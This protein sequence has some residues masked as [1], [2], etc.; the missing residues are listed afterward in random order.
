MNTFI[1]ITIIICIIIFLVCSGVTGFMSYRTYNLEK[2]KIIRPFIGYEGEQLVTSNGESQ[3]KCP[4]GQKIN[5]IGAFYDVYD[6]YLQCT[7]NPDQTM[8]QTCA[9][10]MSDPNNSGKYIPIIGSKCVE[11]KIPPT[12]MVQCNVQHSDGTGIWDYIEPDENGDCNIPNNGNQQADVSILETSNGRKVCA[13][14]FCRNIDKNGENLTCGSNISGNTK[15]YPQ[16]ATAF[17]SEKCNG[18]EV[19]TVTVNS[20]NF[21]PVP[22][23]NNNTPIQS[24]DCS[25]TY[26]TSPIGTYCSLPISTGNFT[27]GMSINSQDPFRKLTSRNIGYKA[28]GIY[29]CS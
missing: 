21:G 1:I 20:D 4:S 10:E 8:L 28:H 14:T 2:Q 26:L 29:S 13:Y 16:D 11:E 19:C 25:Q 6:P 23:F 18:Q 17:L 7:P 12:A 3:I 24:E 22:C 15:C 5:I 27:P 9:I